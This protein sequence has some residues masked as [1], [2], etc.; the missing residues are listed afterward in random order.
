MSHMLVRCNRHALGGGV[1]GIG[2]SLSSLVSAQ[3]AEPATVSPTVE[4]VAAPTSAQ[5]QDAPP[6]KE[7]P[8]LPPLDEASRAA[9]PLAIW[10]SLGW[11]SLAGFAFGLSYSFN[12]HITADAA[13]GVASIGW[14]SGVRVRYNL[15]ESNWTPTIG[16]G[17]QYGPGAKR[18]VMRG[19]ST[20]FAPNDAHADALVTIEPSAFAQG[21]VGMSYQGKGGF[22]ALFGVG[23]SALLDKDNVQAHSGGQETVKLVRQVVGSGIAIEITLGYAF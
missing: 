10:G 19:N 6:L 16:V 5:N 23:Y 12:P 3:S 17:L 22:N 13:F 20:M 9:R 14:K 11:N 15:L 2:L 4:P 7:S 18:V 1:L 21:I 8:L